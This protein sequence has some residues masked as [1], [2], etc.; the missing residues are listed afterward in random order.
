MRQIG[1]YLLLVFVFSFPI[2][3]L[4]AQKV[5]KVKK[6]VGKWEVSGNM[7]LENAEERAFLEAKKE[8]LRQAGI[9][10]N[11]WSVFGQI[12]QENG[13]E[14]QEVYSQ[15]SAIAI[16]G[17]LNVTKKTVDES[18]DPG[19]KRLFKIVTI[20]A[21]VKEGEQEDRSYVLEL[22][23]IESIYKESESFSC[24]VKVHGTDSYIKFFWFDQSGG[25]LLYPNEYEQNQI[26]KKDDTY[27]FPLSKNIDYKMEKM[28]KNLPS[29]K[30]NIMV[31]ATKSDIPYIGEVN[32]TALLKWI[33]TIPIDQ[34]CTFYQMVLVK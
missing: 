24:S 10:E 13:D 29:E 11:V 12:T 4:I 16:G 14:F 20:D 3:T 25:S 2:S 23:G 18:W 15:V 26:F 5:V 17:M 31:V 34:R 21:Q 6:V 32:Y 22:T 33:Y 30:V 1:I 9:M 27:H 28:K 8:A 7:T 19:S